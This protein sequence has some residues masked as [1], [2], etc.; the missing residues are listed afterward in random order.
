MLNP[1]HVKTFYRT[2]YTLI[3]MRSSR[4][5]LAIPF[6]SLPLNS[7]GTSYRTHLQTLLDI[8]SPSQF[9]SAL[10]YTAKHLC[11]VVLVTAYSVLPSLPRRSDSTHTPKVEAP[12]YLL[13]SHLTSPEQLKNSHDNYL[14][15]IKDS[16]HR[17]GHSIVTVYFNHTDIPQHSLACTAQS[18][19]CNSF[20]FK[21]KLG[22]VTE[23]GITKI[24]VAELAALIRDI[25]QSNLPF[26]FLTLNIVI[27]LL[28]QQT[29][30]ILRA[31]VQLNILIDQLK[32]HALITT[33]EGFGWERLFYNIAKETSN[34]TTCIGYS[35]AILR[36]RDEPFF[37]ELGHASN[38]DVILF[39]S[40]AA[41]T[42]F[43]SL[44]RKNQIKTLQVGTSKAFDKALALNRNQDKN[45]VLFVP[46]GTF[47][48]S[49]AFLS[50]ASAT[51]RLLPQQR[52][53]IRFH[54]LI[55]P[56]RVFTR[57]RENTPPNLELSKSSLADDAITCQYVVYRSSSCAIEMTAYG[58][59][60]VFFDYDGNI[61]V[62]SFGCSSY[63]LPDP[64]TISDSFELADIISH[65]PL[66]TYSRQ[67]LLEFSRSYFSTPSQHISDFLSPNLGC[68]K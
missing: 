31:S 5:R 67:A 39:S 55:R 40:S 7:L 12:T 59:L 22:F 66:S 48:I 42:L 43:K 46:E 54:P 14:Q 16:L 62:N 4:V 2:S 23:L 41:Q 44:S 65:Y 64:P 63:P 15:I 3:R 8:R 13:V 30:N 49:L 10:L 61:D 47:D 32:P 33:Y 18:S 45:H 27:Q 24:I 20:I 21:K 29:R 60:P 19:S 28:G 9:L 50:L 6:L 11:E 68:H 17:T 34:T 25:H 38:P 53:K 52:F 56:S 58:A 26:S 35:H 1:L 57:L 36:V 51:A 37:R